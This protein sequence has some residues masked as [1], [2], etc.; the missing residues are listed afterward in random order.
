MKLFVSTM[1]GVGNLIFS[2][3]SGLVYCLM[4]ATAALIL[5]A[6]WVIGIIFNVGKGLLLLGLFFIYFC[7]FIF[8][9]LPIKWLSALAIKLIPTKYDV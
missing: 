6:M 9:Y 1:K 2:A 5:S 7:L 4:I 3:F 8:V